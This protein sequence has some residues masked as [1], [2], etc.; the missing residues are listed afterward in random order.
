M[1]SLMQIASLWDRKPVA[2]EDDCLDALEFIKTADPRLGK[3]SEGIGHCLRAMK[4]DD[5]YLDHCLG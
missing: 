5:T 2:E 4:M 3:V 1:K